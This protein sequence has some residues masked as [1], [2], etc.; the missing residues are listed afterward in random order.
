MLAEIPN[1]RLAVVGFGAYRE[2]C[3]RIVDALAQ[4][5]LTALRELAAQ[6]RAAEGG[7]QAPLRLF[8][9]F[10]D[11]LDGEAGAEGRERYLSAAA[12]MRERVVF[13]GRLEHDEVADVL[14]ACEAMVVPSTFP[15]SFGMVAAEAAAC[16]ALP[17]SA[18][19]SGLAEVSRV[20][21]AELP[22]PVGDLVSFPLAG[23][24]DP[25]DR[26]AADHLAAD[27]RGASATPLERRSWRRSPPTSRGRASR[28]R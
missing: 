1:A 18:A 2:A 26:V 16:G 6:G 12:A 11:W 17:I 22:V 23:T 20:L 5:D 21:A 7:P 24:G 27:A 3:E 19:H 9:E 28:G 10:L 13:T 14:P 4:G 15:E 8:T 25:V